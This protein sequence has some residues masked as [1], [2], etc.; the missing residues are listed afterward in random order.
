LGVPRAARFPLSCMVAVQVRVIGRGV[1]GRG[2]EVLVA[3]SA[4]AWC[5]VY[6]AEGAIDGLE[7]L[8]PNLRG[9]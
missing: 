6:I 8:L 2:Q 9:G 1:E 4:E 5:R 7:L 3:A